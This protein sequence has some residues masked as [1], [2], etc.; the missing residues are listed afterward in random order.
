MLIL[1]LAFLRLRLKSLM[2][3]KLSLS[4]RIKKLNISLEMMKNF[5]N[6]K[7]YIHKK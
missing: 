2:H 4:K 6:S 3:G 7:K 1:K 5:Y